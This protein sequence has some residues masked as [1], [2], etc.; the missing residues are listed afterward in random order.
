VRARAAADAEQRHR[1]V[2]G[3]DA[4]ED[5]GVI[6]PAQPAPRAR[7]RAMERRADTEHGGEQRRI[8]GDDRTRLGPRT[9]D[10]DDARDHRRGKRDPVHDPAQPRSGSE[11][12]RRVHAATMPFEARLGSRD[13][14]QSS[15][16]TSRLRQQC[17]I[18][19]VSV[20]W[21]VSAS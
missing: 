3:E 19:A 21:Y 20:A 1:Q 5:R 10:E 16:T 17:V 18:D 15:V 7:W 11:E 13:S 9:G 6:E 14:G 12:V 8:D 2:G 4:R